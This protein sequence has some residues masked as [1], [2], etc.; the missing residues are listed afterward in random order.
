MVM[1]FNPCEEENN[2]W[3]CNNSGFPELYQ[4]ERANFIEQN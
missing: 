4:I 1:G 3:R 2:V